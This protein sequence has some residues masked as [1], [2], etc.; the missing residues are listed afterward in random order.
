MMPRSGPGRDEVTAAATMAAVYGL[1]MNHRSLL[2]LAIVAAL[3]AGTAEDASARPRPRARKFEA[4]KTFGLGLML[5]APSGLSGK[6]FYGPSTAFDFGVGAIR[7]YRNRDGVHL[8]V[9]HLWHPVSL[10]HNRSFELPLYV[11][12]GARVFDFDGAG[13][14]IGL[15]APLGIAFDF[16]DAP[17][18]LFFEFALVLDTYLDGDDG[19]DADVNFA[20]GA[21]FWFGE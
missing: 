6:Y 2:A 5:G 7:Y 11:G 16:N 15:R 3:T 10:A 21:R 9:D 20:V 14:S 8:H 19:L 12:L 4:N 13:S 1:A 17:V 18:D